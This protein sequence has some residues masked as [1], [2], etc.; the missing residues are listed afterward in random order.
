MSC[1]NSI[2]AL[3]AIS[4]A[5]RWRKPW[6]ELVA[7]LLMPPVGSLELVLS[8]EPPWLHLPERNLSEYRFVVPIPAIILSVYDV[9]DVQ[10]RSTLHISYLQVL[11]RRKY[12]NILRL[13]SF[14]AVFL[15]EC[16]H[17]SLTQ[18]S[19][20]M[21]ECWGLVTQIWD[22]EKFVQV[23]AIFILWLFLN[24]QAC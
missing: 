4:A 5:R 16:Y 3:M 18:C 23:Y 24:T 21:L 10:R 1:S 14:A 19:F 11:W 12:W 17:H 22:K 9:H 2:V 7:S 20:C 13:V 6:S 8:R 15:G